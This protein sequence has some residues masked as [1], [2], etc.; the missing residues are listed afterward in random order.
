MAL[1]R[2]R[3]RGWPF[4][5]LDELREEMDRL[6][7]RTFGRT[8]PVHRETPVIRG[9][10]PAVDMFERENEV[11]LR[12]EVPGMAKEDIDISVS[13]N[14]LTISGER[15]TEEEIKDEDYYHCERSYGRFQRALSLPQGVDAE[16]IKASY[17]NGILEVTIPKQEEAKPKKI[18]VAVE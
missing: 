4:R 18:E 6:F 14:T 16:N 10:A 17:K 2:W 3:D 1:M 13:G 11:V 7:E 8:L 15:K 12:A 5:E 9:W